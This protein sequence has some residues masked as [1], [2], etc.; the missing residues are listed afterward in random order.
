MTLFI[1]GL[2]IYINNMAW[3]WYAIAVVVWLAHI[4]VRYF[5]LKDK[6]GL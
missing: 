6:L 4:G 5:V 3:W 2:L 1:A